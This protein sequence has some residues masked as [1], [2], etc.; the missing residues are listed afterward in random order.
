MVKPVKL[1]IES[2]YDMENIYSLRCKLGLS[3]AQMYRGI[4]KC[5]IPLYCLPHR[6]NSVF[7]H[8]ATLWRFAKSAAFKKYVCKVEMNEHM[9]DH[10]KLNIVRKDYDISD[11]V[12]IED[13]V[14][15]KLLNLSV[16]Q[17]VSAVKVGLIPCIDNYIMVPW[18]TKFLKGELEYPLPKRGNKR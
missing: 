12:T 9:V 1:H 2:I 16:E 8:C 4:K 5:E 17:A 15:D 3:Q 10:D 7:I 14:R 6:R 13:A 11:I 18:F